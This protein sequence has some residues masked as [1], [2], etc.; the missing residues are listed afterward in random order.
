MGIKSWAWYIVGRYYDNPQLIKLFCY[1]SWLPVV[2]LRTY[3]RKGNRYVEKTGNQCRDFK[4]GGQIPW[5]LTREQTETTNLEVHSID[6]SGIYYVAYSNPGQPLSSASEVLE[7]Q[8]CSIPSLSFL[9]PT[10]SLP[11]LPF[12]PPPN[13]F[14]CAE[15]WT[16]GHAPVRQVL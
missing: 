14:L 5:C 13:P 11:L 3:G 6:W 2:R 1:K 7:L 8:V 4:P 12:V 15:G 9:P 16:Q 10:L